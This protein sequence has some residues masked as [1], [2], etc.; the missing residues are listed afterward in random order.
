MLK[1]ILVDT[2]RELLAQWMKDGSRL[3]AQILN[4]YAR[5]TAA[6]GEARRECSKLK[7]DFAALREE[8]DRVKKERREA[9]D[10]IAAALGTASAALS[11]FPDAPAVMT[12][13]PVTEAVESVAPLP[14]VAPAEAGIDP[15][16][17]A[18][19]PTPVPTPSPPEKEPGALR[20]L[21]ILVVDDEQTFRDM[22][23]W[24]LR[25]RYEVTTAETGEEALRLLENVGQSSSYSISGCPGWAAWKP[26]DA[27]KRYTRTC[28]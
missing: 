25:G 27:S 10:T 19:T 16:A 21:H 14:P 20:P 18:P 4:D 11:R 1:S 6:L 8:N 17:L 7:E 22:L 5:V 9:L 3:L 15:P 24:H 12:V 13:T 2:T 28:V 23:A 26:C